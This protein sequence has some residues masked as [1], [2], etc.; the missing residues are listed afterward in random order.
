MM[1]ETAD[2][3]ARVAVIVRVAAEWRVQAQLAALVGRADVLVDG[4]HG[5]QYT[6]GQLLELAQLHRFLH[7]MILQVVHSLG[8]LE[9]A[10]TGDRQSVHVRELAL[11]GGVDVISGSE[12]VRG[13]F[14]SANP[15]SL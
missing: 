13:R 15:R 6:A 9:G 10:R 2:H 14:S 5:F 3:V 12:T 1:T 8:G 11:L 4:I 7:A